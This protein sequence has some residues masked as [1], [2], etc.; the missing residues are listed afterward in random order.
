[1]STEPTM[2]RQP[3]KPTR[4]MMPP[5]PNMEFYRA[6]I[7]SPNCFVERTFAW[8]T[9]YRRL[10]RDYEINSRQSEAMI[11]LAVI[12]LLLKRIA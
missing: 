12:H 4:F 9:N 2:P 6:N 10:N 5:F 11:K 1:M 7:M 8:L 3:T